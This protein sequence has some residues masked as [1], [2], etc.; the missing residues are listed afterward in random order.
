[1]RGQREIR[2]VPACGQYLL[3]SGHL[4]DSY[5]KINIAHGPQGDVRI[6]P[7]RQGSSLQKSRL[8]ALAPEEPEDG[9]EFMV[10]QD[11][12]GQTGKVLPS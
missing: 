4:A 8:K 1:M 10:G 12:P 6:D 3:C 9:A 2:N 7:P 5:Q 11:I